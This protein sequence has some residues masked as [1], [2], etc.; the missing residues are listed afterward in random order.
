MRFMFE[1]DDLVLVKTHKN[2]KL[3]V[4]CY[5]PKFFVKYL[6]SLYLFAEV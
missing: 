6:T 3:G 5:G 1:N 4:V 2:S